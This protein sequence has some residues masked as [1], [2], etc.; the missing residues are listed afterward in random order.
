MADRAQPRLGGGRVEG[1][2]VP[3][4]RHVGR[5][6]GHRPLPLGHWHRERTP[7][8]LALQPES[9][10]A[11]HPEDH[12]EQPQQSAVAVLRPDEYDVA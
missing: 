11:A 5:E 8:R 4:R 1:E 6:Q 10:A 2:P 3:G 7:L 9:A 12:L